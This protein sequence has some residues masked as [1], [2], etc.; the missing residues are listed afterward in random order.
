MV[1]PKAKAGAQKKEVAHEVRKEDL[2]AGLLAGA[3]EA[4]AHAR[5]SP[6]AHARKE[7]GW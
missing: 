6:H 2:Q 5:S 3:G 1:D 7:L 4:N